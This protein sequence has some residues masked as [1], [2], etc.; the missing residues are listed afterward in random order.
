MAE[1]SDPP[2]KAKQGSD[3]FAAFEENINEH[4]FSGNRN[5]FKAL[6]QITGL[7]PEWA[8]KKQ[9]TFPQPNLVL[10]S[11]SPRRQ[12]LMRLTGRSFR[13]H[14]PDAAAERQ[15]KTLF[16]GKAKN[17]RLS[18]SDA[19]KDSMLLAAGKA[20]NVYLKE[21]GSCGIWIGADTI[22]Y[23]D[24]HVLGKPADQDEARQML[25]RL[26]GK[27][28]LVMTGVSVLVR[29]FCRPEDRPH[30]VFNPD[31]IPSDLS[32]PFLQEETFFYTTEVHFRPLDALQKYYIDRYVESGSPLDKAGGYGIQDQGALL[33]HSIVGDYHN[34]VGLPVAGLARCLDRLEGKVEPPA[35]F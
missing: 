33:I 26:S 25:Y 5:H 10:C 35:V 28:H 24:G 34:V 15:L 12:A 30:S 9:L 31:R 2:A 29:G 27:K 8:G 14:E 23:L 6:D 20:R 21:K 19:G 32:R 11:A 16:D 4:A 7:T 1:N 18:W 22:V 3:R 17:K 13:T